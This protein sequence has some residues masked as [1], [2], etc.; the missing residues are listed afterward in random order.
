MELFPRIAKNTQDSLDKIYS[1]VINDSKSMDAWSQIGLMI[2]KRIEERNIHSASAIARDFI[3]RIK[4]TV[5][6]TISGATKYEKNSED[7]I[8]LNAILGFNISLEDI[9]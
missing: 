2:T 5:Y 9:E 1:T 8:C 3:I 7:V 4:N 6:D